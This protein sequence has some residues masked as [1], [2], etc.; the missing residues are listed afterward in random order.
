[1]ENTRKQLEDLQTEFASLYDSGAL[2]GMGH[3]H[4]QVSYKYFKQLVNASMF[5]NIITLLET[6]PDGRSKAIING[7]TFVAIHY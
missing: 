4:I 1:M 3:D 5:D 6:K 7:I 2:I